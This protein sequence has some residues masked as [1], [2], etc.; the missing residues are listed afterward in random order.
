MT[1]RDHNNLLGIFFMINGGLA[2]LVGLVMALAYGGFGVAMLGT[3]RREEE[4]IA[5]GIMFVAGIV[6]SLIVFVVAAFYLFTGIKLRKLAPVGRT[7]GLIASILALFNFPLGTALG[8]YGLW[9][10]LGDMG[11]ALYSGSGQS[12][13]APPPNS[14]Q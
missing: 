7:L 11:K 12:Y 9:F 14:W 3:A 4:Q 8:V 2:L 5:G 13:S 6:I 10:L 1:A